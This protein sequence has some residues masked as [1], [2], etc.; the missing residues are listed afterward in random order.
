MS[1]EEFIS[2]TQIKSTNIQQTNKI[3]QIQG[4]QNNGYIMNVG[5]M[6]DPHDI[7]I[8]EFDIPNFKCFM[9]SKIYEIVTLTE[10]DVNNLFQMIK[11]I[12]CKDYDKNAKVGMLCYNFKP[13]ESVLDKISDQ[14][15]K[16]LIDGIF[17]V[18]LHFADKYIVLKQYDVFPGNE[19]MMM[20][21]TE[22]LL[23]DD[24]QN[25]IKYI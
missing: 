25:L 14:K 17:S 2:V 21:L 19:H 6:K 15:N 22:S 7:L 13:K 9:V 18:T 12:I 8:K 10:S 24:V 3:Y 5:H 16:I 4:I 1:N 23:S 20:H 11:I